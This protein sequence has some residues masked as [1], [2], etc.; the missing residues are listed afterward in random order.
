MIFFQHVSRSHPL[1]STQTGG[2]APLSEKTLNDV[3]VPEDESVNLASNSK[4]QD[5]QQSAS[6]NM[7]HQQAQQNA[8]QN[9]VQN[10]IFFPRNEEKYDL[11]T[12]IANMRDEI[13]DFLLFKLKQHGIKWHLSAQVELVKEDADGNITARCKPHFRSITYAT[14]NEETFSQHEL[15]EA[16]NKLSK[17]LETYFRDSSGWIIQRV[18]KLT[19]LTV[20]YS[21]LKGSTYIPLPNTLKY[22]NCILNIKNFTDEMCFLYCVLASLYPVKSQPE[23]V[24]HYKN[25]HI[26]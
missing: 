24:E 10:R 14:L 16:F 26:N 20:K 23:M 15:N 2:R 22:S 21:P 6:Q 7:P 5:T 8:L 12:F 19:A 13:T 18:I 25:L 11:L 1:N 4:H 3:E 17:S 9:A